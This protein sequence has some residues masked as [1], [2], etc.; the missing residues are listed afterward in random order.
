MATIAET[1]EGSERLEG[2]VD[3]LME[4]ESNPGKAWAHWMG[5]EM[6]IHGD[7]RPSFLKETF[8]M[9]VIYNDKSEDL[10]QQPT[11][12][13]S[14]QSPVPTYPPRQQQQHQQ[15]QQQHLK[16]QQWQPQQTQT[17]SPIQ[18]STPI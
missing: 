10:R 14:N 8:K 2:R 6:C 9:M 1:I 12:G 16:Q 18:Q 4:V 11:P 7:L 3:Q 15:Q 5:T 13:P 17:F